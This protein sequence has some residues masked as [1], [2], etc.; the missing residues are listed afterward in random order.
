MPGVTH[1]TY[2]SEIL[3]LVIFYSMTLGGGGVMLGS[4]K[5]KISTHTDGVVRRVPPPLSI[6]HCSTKCGQ[7]MAVH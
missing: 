3:T 1:P 5:K 6:V 2:P 4:Q 7:K